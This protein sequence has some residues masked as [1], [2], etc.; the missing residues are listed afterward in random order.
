MRVVVTKQIRMI[1]MEEKYGFKKENC[2][3]KNENYKTKKENCQNIKEKCPTKSECENILEKY[4]TPIH[5]RKHCYAVS[6]TA[7]SIAEALNNKGLKL[8]V[9]LVRAAG[10]LH[11][12]ARV[13]KNHDKVGADY[14]SSIGYKKVANVI[15][16]HTKHKINPDIGLL[17]EE[18]VLCIADRVVLQ[19]NYVGPKKRMDYI[20]SKAI[21]KY[22]QDSRDLL[23]SIAKEFV[24]FIYALEDF[25]GSPLYKIVPEDIREEKYKN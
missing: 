22:G 24:N 20:M 5:V 21:L 9:D 23:D 2:K 15:K 7:G 11:D 3:I 17:D 19:S 13:E 4:N 12:I 16:N 1:G 10:Y 8:D 18:D 25:I 6:K 14:L